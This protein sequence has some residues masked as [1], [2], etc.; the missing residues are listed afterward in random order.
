MKNWFRNKCKEFDLATLT[1]K[2]EDAVVMLALQK[3]DCVLQLAL[4]Q[5]IP[6]GLHESELA[7]F[8]VRHVATAAPAPAPVSASPAPSGQLY[9]T[10]IDQSCV[11]ALVAPY[12]AATYTEVEQLRKKLEAQEE[13]NTL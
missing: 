1:S 3:V 10:T 11:P 12:D 9:V 13:C 4:S 6:D 5:S 2:A 8:I 7:D